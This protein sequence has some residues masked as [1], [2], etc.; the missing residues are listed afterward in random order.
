MQ[1]YILVREVREKTM[2]PFG[3]FG[4]YKIERNSEFLVEN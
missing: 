1:A 2:E 3:G 4:S